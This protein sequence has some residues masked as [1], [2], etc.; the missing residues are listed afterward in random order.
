MFFLRADRRDTGD[1]VVAC[2]SGKLISF[3]GHYERSSAKSSRLS[4]FTRNDGKYR[5]LAIL[6][7][8][9]VF[10]KPEFQGQKGPDM[11]GKVHVSGGMA[12]ENIF[13]S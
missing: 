11:R 7:L 9:E 2:V 6:P 3:I 5:I 13:D 4:N 1:D 8:S 12:M 10:F